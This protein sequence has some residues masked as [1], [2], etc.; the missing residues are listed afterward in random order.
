MG[1][2]Q[3]PSLPHREGGG[4]A[5]LRDD[6]RGVARVHVHYC[7]SCSRRASRRGH[8]W[9]DTTHDSC[10][11]IFP[12]DR[13]RDSQPARTSFRVREWGDGGGPRGSGPGTPRPGSG[14]VGALRGP[15]TVRERTGNPWRRR[16]LR[17]GG[18]R[19]A[20]R[21]R[22]KPGQVSPAGVTS[23]LARSRSGP[24]RPGY[25]RQQ[26]PDDG[27]KKQRWVPSRRRRLPV[28]EVG[29][30]AHLRRYELPD[31]CERRS[32]GPGATA[33]A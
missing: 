16:R 31:D 10:V 21:D 29:K 25:R 30:D 14:R 3:E 11:P 20:Q 24:A 28:V 15:R 13:V 26:G 22:R 18:E 19:E 1:T 4:L 32:L 33:P 23:A 2:G 27:P 5:D 7:L 12:R 9:I 8:E 17:G 6:D